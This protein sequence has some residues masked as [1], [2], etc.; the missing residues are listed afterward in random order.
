MPRDSVSFR[1][2]LFAAF[3]LPVFALCAL[4]NSGNEPTAPIA[5]PPVADSMGPVKVPGITIKNF[6]VVDGRIFRGGQPSKKEY[7]QLAALGVKVVIDLRLDAKKTSRELAEAAGLRYVNIP[8]DGHGTPSDQHSAEFLEVVREAGTAPVY[9]HCAGGR[10]RTG[11]MVAV[12]RMTCNGWNAEQAYQEM[13]DYD[14]YTAWGHEGFKTYVLD[15]YS[16][17]LRDP[18][19]VPSASPPAEPVG[20]VTVN[21]ASH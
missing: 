9:A 5:P 10:H 14:F 17:M 7:A 12:Y 11:S 16:R 19:S 20:S 13:L 1:R 2:S 3:V 15:F 21:A 6:G 18:S 8:I 4:A